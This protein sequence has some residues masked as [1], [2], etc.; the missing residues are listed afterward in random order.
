MNHNNYFFLKQLTAELDGLLRGALFV[1]AYSTSKQEL[2]LLFK[3]HAGEYLQF[4]FSFLNT[5]TVLSFPA[6]SNN[7]RNKHPHFRPVVSQE[8]MEVKQHTPERSFHI[9]FANNYYLLVKLFGKNGNVLLIN[10][11]QPEEVF[12]RQLKADQQQDFSFAHIQKD[13]DSNTILHAD[14]VKSLQKQFPFIPAD[15]VEELENKGFFS[16]P[17]EKRKDILSAVLNTLQQPVFYICKA[18][19]GYQLRFFPAGETLAAYNE[20]IAAINDFARLYLGR[21]FFEDKK[22]RII[23]TLKQRQEK[24]EKEIASKKIKLQTIATQTP[25]N[26]I[27]DI[28]MANLYQLQ[29]GLDKATL[30]NFYTDKEIEIRLKKELSPQENAENYY[31]KAKNQVKETTILKENLEKAE[32]ELKEITAKLDTTLAATDSK[33]LRG[34]EKEREAV[35]ENSKP[36]LFKEFERSGYTILVGKNSENNDVL[37]QKYAHKNDVWLHA[38]GMAGSHV[39]IKHKPG[40]TTPADVLE[41]AASLAAYFSKGRTDSLCPV[42]YTEKKYVRKPKGSAP[43]QVSVEK[44][45]VLL[46]K[47]AFSGE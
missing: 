23:Q 35:E 47:P 30:H 33:A 14:S 43:G 45:K 31:R 38:R 32:S 3:T 27:A 6:E 15:A 2:W 46:V 18:E 24:L 19:T 44:E 7:P 22:N 41:Y 17:A 13:I 21:Y 1:E 36:S 42:I 39:V 25:Y 40:K 16:S 26:H 8:V 12:R 11:N 9:R 37:T 4:R 10:N 20:P 29:K 34:M 5:D 28:L